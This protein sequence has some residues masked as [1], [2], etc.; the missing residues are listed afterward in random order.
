MKHYASINDFFTDRLKELKCDENVKS[1][2]ISIF[3]KY[4][5]SNYDL[6]KESITAQYC[7]AKL[8]NNFEKFQNIA[9][10]LFMASSI[11][12]ESLKGASKDY[13]YNIGRFSYFNCYRIVRQWQIYELLADNFIHLSNDSG[14]IIRNQTY[15]DKN[16]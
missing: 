12:P 8:N 7:D 5:S 15:E 16:I 3:S 14:K 6:S 1:Y 13:Y 2:I 9:D 4:K 10:W 11:F